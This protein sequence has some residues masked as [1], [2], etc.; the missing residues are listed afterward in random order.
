MFCFCCCWW[1]TLLFFVYFYLNWALWN[2]L[3][4]LLQVYINA[5]VA[6]VVQ[7]VGLLHNC[8]HTWHTVEYVV[9]SF[10]FLPPLLLT[11][12]VPLLRSARIKITITVSGALV[13][14]FVVAQFIGYF[15]AHFKHTHKHSHI[16]IE[17]EWDSRICMRAEFTA[18]FFFYVFFLFC[19]FN[20]SF[21]FYFLSFICYYPLPLA[22]YAVLA[23]SLTHTHTHAHDCSHTF[24]SIGFSA[25]FS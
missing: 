20:F 19:N 18:K 12:R 16:N 5:D 8:L 25:A 23:R 21:Y 1:I 7:F 17:C 3:L 13:V 2:W 11:L 22:L 24:D 4:L 15:Y 6:T 10:L 14:A 9:G